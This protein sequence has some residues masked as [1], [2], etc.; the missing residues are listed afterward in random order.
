M[1]KL[2]TNSQILQLAIAYGYEYKA[3]K[4]IIQVESGQH[5]FSQKT[6]KIIIQFE[7]AWFR[8]LDHEWKS[9]TKHVLW[10]SN[11]VGDQ[12]VE[13]LAF[14]DAFAADQDAAMQSTSIGMMQIMGFHYAELGFKTVGAM[15]DFAKLSEYNQVLLALKWIGTVPALRKALK[16]KDW[17][18]VAYYYNGANYKEF[19]YDTRL[20]AAYRLSDDL[21]LAA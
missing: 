4:S 9:D 1:N 7:P 3:L 17:A 12:T 10:Q 6:G 15:W 19:H 5:G 16:A 21:K 14:N 8:R 2:L 13:W 20:A 18:K 11:K